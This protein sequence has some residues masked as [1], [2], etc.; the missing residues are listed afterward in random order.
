MTQDYERKDNRPKCVLRV[1]G[2]RIIMWRMLLLT[3]VILSSF[4]ISG[5][6]FLAGI[7]SLPFFFFFLVPCSCSF[8]FV[9]FLCLHIS[10][11]SK[12]S[13]IL[14]FWTPELDCLWSWKDSSCTYLQC[15]RWSSV[16]VMK[17]IIRLKRGPLADNFHS[18][19]RIVK[20]GH[21]SS[22]TQIL[23]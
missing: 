15:G 20:D 8:L 19:E 11:F 13:S 10:A 23:D 18:S 14:F 16:K 7:H 4:A 6:P 9:L 12:M 21:S 17:E 2:P 5:A 1:F 22:Q 3:F